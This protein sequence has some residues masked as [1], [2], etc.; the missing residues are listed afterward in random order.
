[1][2]RKI[3]LIL[4][5]GWGFDKSC[6]R[7][8][9]PHLRENQDCEINIQTP[10]RGYFGPSTQV[11]P[12]SE[13]NSV[14]VVVAHSLGLHLVP[15]EILQS[16]DLLVLAATFSH[17]HGG[18]RLEQKRSTKTVQLMHKRLF[19]APMDVLNDFYSNCYHPLLT[20]HMLLMRNVGSLD[21][22]LLAADLELL[23]SNKFDT[24]KLQAV[25]KILLVHGSED[26]VVPPSHS[27]ELN[28][29]LP[30]SSLVLF[31]GAGHSLP[32]THVAPVWIS[33]RNTLRHLLAVNA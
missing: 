20:S 17:F 3:E 14:K 24:T 2:K 1:M 10:D 28:E 30:S 7:G 16:A 5:H 32:L 8:W 11:N 22:E 15:V 12:F 9:M 21:T 25:Q 29:A 4:Q 13:A 6:W 27:H 23:D 31:E 26:S 33:L 18:S 19:E